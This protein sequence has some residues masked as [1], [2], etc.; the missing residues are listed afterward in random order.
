MS[1]ESREAAWG[2]LVF[3]LH[4]EVVVVPL[5]QPGLVQPVLPQFL[6]PLHI[7][8]GTPA[9]ASLT[10]LK[11][12]LNLDIIILLLSFLPFFRISNSIV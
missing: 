6:L 1:S 2:T 3:P 8:P 4:R 9:A 10:S 12:F 5:K 7:L 11:S